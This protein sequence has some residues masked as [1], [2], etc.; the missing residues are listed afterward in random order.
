[1]ADPQVLGPDGVLRSDVIFSTSVESRFFSGVIP[2]DAVEVQVSIN[3]SGFS[4]EPSLVEWG[5]GNWVVPNPTSEPNG[6]LLLPGDNI[7]RVRVILP[8]GSTS[9]SANITVRLVSDIDI[10]VVAAV[11]T[12]ISVEQLNRSVTIRSES[13][14]D[15]GFRGMNFYAS[16]SAGGGV[17]GYTRINVNTV[18]TGH[19]VQETERF[20]L[21][22]ID[23]EVLVDPEGT[24]VADPQFFRV[25]GQQEDKSER[26]LQGDLSQAFEIPETAREVRVTVTLDSVQGVTL[27]EFN[28]SRSAGPNSTPATVRVG[29][30]SSLSDEVPLFY[31]VTAVYYDSRRNLE[32][33]SSYS[34]EVVGHPTTVTT[35]LSSIPS[36][37]RQDIV[38]EFIRSVRRSQPQVKVEAGAVLRDTVIDPYSKESERLRF[39]L[40]FFHRSRTPTLLLQVDDP[41][42]TGVSI[43]VSQSPYK[44]GLQVALYL[45]NAQDVQGVIDATFEAYASNY[46]K[47]RRS[48]ISSQT[49]VTF[50]TSRRPNS[51]IVI[52][53]GTIVAGGGVQFTT[54]RASS[55]AF[56]RLAS[57]FDPVS[58]RYQVNVP[59]RSLK[60]GAKGNVGVGQISTIVTNLRGSLSVT[61]TAPA[62]G[63]KDQE[64]NL[65]LTVRVRNALASVDSGTARGYLQTAADVGG[66]IQANVVAAGNGLMQRDLDDQGVHRGGKVDVWIQGENLATVTDTFAFAFTIAQDV[67]FEVIGN[68]AD[69]TFR[70]LD[71]LLSVENPLVEMLEDPAAGFEFRNAS[72]GLTFDLT[73]VSITSFDTIKL[74]TALAQPPVDLS[75]VVLGSYRRRTG[76]TFVLPRQPVQSIALVTG[77]VSGQLP[78]AAFLLVRPDAPLENGH[79]TLAQDFLQI[80]RVT[81]DSGNQVPSGK[82]L[83][84]TQEEHV[85]IG[86]NPEYLDNLGAN[87]LTLVVTS[88]DGTLTYKGPRDPSGDPDYQ[89]DIGTPTTALSITRTETGNIPSGATVLVSYEHDENFTV[90]YTTNLIVSQ[91]QDAIDANKHATADV[92]AKDSLPIPLDVEATVVLI[93]GRERSTVDTALRT[94]MEN[95]FNNLRLGDPV[96]Q[97]DIISVIEQTEGVSFVVT[98]LSKMVPQQGATI[99][100]EAIS[101]DTASESTFVSDL[102]TNAAS[103]YLLNNAMLYATTDGGGPEGEFKAVFEDDIAMTLLEATASLTALGVAAGRAYIIGNEGRSIEGISDDATLIAQGFVTQTA[104]DERRRELTAN[105]ILVSVAVGSA[106]TSF[107][108]A[109]TYI[110]GDDS[111]AKNVDPGI[112]QY[113]EAG[114]LLFTFDEDR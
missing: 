35:A 88:E 50:F 17:R 33:E 32:Y 99:V 89:V 94:N 106:P 49:E 14:S 8:S 80:N 20:G 63:G 72:A 86:Q 83:S 5:G 30:F 58:G 21:A 45:D 113:V 75:D 51:T 9:P 92:L 68:P 69:L 111:E 82:T 25:I 67:Q 59:V 57:F 104:L 64:S 77:T 103:V 66:V 34:E 13:S 48:G 37:D 76:N 93:R 4:S 81:D 73:N 24:P 96:R 105:H 16:V 19:V 74:N 23:A 41:N 26:V 56:E 2:N 36:V 18:G 60:I 6:L 12:N 102:S 95:F 7:I 54:T 87:F 11:P 44:Q 42:G 40:D 27:Y 22:T 52:P 29:E 90:T 38:T 100:R 71:T 62:T 53:L 43:P 98:P 61:N 47:R 79:S 101:T 85:L 110:I 91:T 31:V 39:I 55:I 112:A 65:A 3:G 10:G 107:S 46:G 108:Y 114:E 70:A 1:M 28:H 84:A 15:I 109:T 97:S 78:P